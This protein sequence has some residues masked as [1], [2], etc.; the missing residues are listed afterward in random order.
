MDTDIKATVV[1]VGFNGQR[2]LQ[3]CL[4]SLL[5]QDMPSNQYE[6]FFFDNHSIDNS[7]D[8]VKKNF[9]SIKVIASS[10]NLGFF[11]ACNQVST[12]AMGRYLVVLP[13]DT[14]VHRRWLPELIC[15][16][17][18]H[19]QAMIC[20]AN[21]IGPGAIDYPAKARV[22]S[23]SE[24]HYR[25]LSRLGHVTFRSAPFTNQAFWTLACSGV[26]GL[27]KKEIV[28]A[29]G[30]LFEPLMGHY[31]SDMEAGLRAAVVGYGVLCV[32]SAVVYHVG[33][34]NKS[35]GWFV[36][37]ADWG[38]LLRY[39]LGSRDILL[40]YYKNMTLLEFLLALPILILGRAAKCL[41]LRL[42]AAKRIVL[43]LISLAL[44][45]VL[46]VMVLVR[47]PRLAT[48]KQGMAARRTVDR[49]WLLRQL[50]SQQRGPGGCT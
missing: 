29:T 23:V 34:E 49:L 6:V 47:M 44:T 7:I 3:D 38:L 37:A 30:C 36:S 25:E 33:D 16:A 18:Q 19:P 9:P 8:L 24:V 35:L 14:I 4:S 41:E 31:A 5:D 28:A 48:A 10:R 15:A 12:I 39:A 46:L 50:L 40:A 27:F 45:P 22:G 17:Q 2:Y 20:T 42:G 11:P 21:S 43:L 32:P 26:S 1:V 13:Q